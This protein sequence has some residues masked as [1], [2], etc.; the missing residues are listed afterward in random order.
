MI[1]RIS[2]K[3]INVSGIN[4][5]GKS[6]YSQIRKYEIKAAFETYADIRQKNKDTGWKQK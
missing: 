4:F 2:V 6:R 5:L 3:L 1:P